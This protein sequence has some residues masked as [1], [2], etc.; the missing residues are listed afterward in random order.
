M[1]FNI[2]NV[3]QCIKNLVIYIEENNL[4]QLYGIN[5]NQDYYNL[6]ILIIM[7]ISVVNKLCKDDL[8]SLVNTVFK[9]MYE[10]DVFSD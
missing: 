2:V 4:E 9:E 8:T 5:V 10:F 7:A 6:N 3:L 1:Q